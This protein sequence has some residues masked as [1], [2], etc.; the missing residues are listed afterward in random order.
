VVLRLDQHR[1]RGGMREW[2]ASDPLSQ[3]NAGGPSGSVKDTP[4]RVA[5]G[6]ASTC[7]PSSRLESVL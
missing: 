4:E 5:E 1:I 6:R 3:L 7:K 2:D